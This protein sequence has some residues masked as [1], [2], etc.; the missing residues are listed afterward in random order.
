MTSRSICRR[1]FSCIS[2]GAVE[3]DTSRHGAALVYPAACEA[4]CLETLQWHHGLRI[5]D[6]A[7][8]Q[9]AQQR[10]EFEPVP[11]EPGGKDDT[12]VGWQAVKNEILV[13]S[14]IVHTRVD[15]CQFCQVQSRQQ[16]A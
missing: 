4:S 15:V 7:A 10:G 6:H 5:T 11:C 8:Q 12:W 9:L 2:L 16:L 1:R 3:H 13:R 14:H